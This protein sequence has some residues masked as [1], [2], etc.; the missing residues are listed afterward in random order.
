VEAVAMQFVNHEPRDTLFM[1]G[2]H[3]NA[4]ALAQ[5]TDEIIFRPWEFETLAL[6][7]Q[8]LLHIAPDH[9]SNVHAN[10]LFTHGMHRG[11]LPC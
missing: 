11:L 3:A 9:P 7:R 10:V 1:L 6:D 4:I 2:H 8:N 5:T